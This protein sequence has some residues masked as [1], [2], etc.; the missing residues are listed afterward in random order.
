MSSTTFIT[1][2][3]NII[4]TKII[5][6]LLGSSGMGVFSLYMGLYQV[7]TSLGGIL[8]GGGVVKFISEYQE[9]LHIVLKV[10]QYI[11]F[12]LTIYSILVSI[13]ILFFSS[14]ISIYL[15]NNEEYKIGIIII[16]LISIIINFSLFYQSWLNGF[17]KIKEIAKV[18]LYSSI[19]ITIFTI[20]IV[21]FYKK[22][23]IVYA[24]AFLPIPPLLFSYYY[25]KKIIIST[26]LTNKLHTKEFMNLVKVGFT[27][28]LIS[29]IFQLGILASRSII[30]NSLGLKELGLI[31]AAW[32]ISMSYIEI[33][34]SALVVDYFPKLSSLK[35]K[36]DKTIELVNEQL[37]FTLLLLAPIIFMSFIFSEYILTLLYNSNF[38]SAVYVL[39]IQLLGDL[40]KVV[41]W[42]LGYLL[43]VQGLLKFSLILQL[44]WISLYLLILKIGLSSFGIE[45]AGIAFLI[46]Y[47]FGTFLTYI[48]LIKKYNFYFMIKNIKLFIYILITATSLICIEFLIKEHIILFQFCIGIIFLFI[49]YSIILIKIGGIKWIKAK[50]QK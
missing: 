46:S 10:K 39:K 6:V 27:L 29:L 7:L 22:S 24:V 32:T 14:T 38:V 8:A 40:F 9:K 25:S 12:L 35:M 30:T 13:C 26:K 16:G 33:F 43:I 31:F 11:V 23:G 15:F 1:M 21:Y 19:V 18:R 4:K 5:A 45:I 42:I 47:F 2:L 17:R 44:M 3:L 28:T 34:L 36:K 41:S 37:F 20:L 50:I 49:S 48:I